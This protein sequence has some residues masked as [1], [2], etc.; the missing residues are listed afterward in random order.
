ML[1]VT[2]SEQQTGAPLMERLDHPVVY[3]QERRAFA[4]VIL[5]AQYDVLL[6][7]ICPPLF[8]KV[9]LNSSMSSQPFCLPE[10]FVS[11]EAI[12]PTL[13][14]A[15]A[16]YHTDNFVGQRIDGYQANRA[17]LTDPAAQALKAVQHE[18]QPFGLGLKIF[19]AYRPQ[20]AVDHFIRWAHDLS[21]TH[22]RSRFYPELEKQR[23]FAE[24]YLACHSSHTRGSTVDLTLIDLASGNELDMGTEFDYF[25]RKSWPDYQDISPQQRTNRMLL[26]QLMVKHGFTTF[27]QEWWHFTLGNEPYPDTWF[28]FPIC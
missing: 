16:Y 10:G 20:Q 3:Q 4:A 13:C 15:L 21:D 22:T 19:D 18:L 2:K 6:I 5:N 25:S 24:G 9:I 23:L 7:C 12:I 11:L 17:L 1:P 28:D 26:Q 27:A 8:L 14:V